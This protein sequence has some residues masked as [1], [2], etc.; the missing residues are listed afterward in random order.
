MLMGLYKVEGCLG[1]KVALCATAWVYT[2][3]G[4]SPIDVMHASTGSAEG[5]SITWESLGLKR[6]SGRAML[7]SCPCMD[8]Q[9]ELWQDPSLSGPVLPSSRWR[10][11]CQNDSGCHEEFGH[12][13]DCKAP[14][15]RSARCTPQL[16]CALMAEERPA[17]GDLSFRHC[18]RPWAMMQEGHQ[19][20]RLAAKL[21]YA[22]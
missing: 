16:V 5:C 2:R 8:A 18:I 3:L 6:L 4:P 1:V 17:G 20:S 9:G 21:A 22:S 7:N 12:I 13:K 10:P 14:L 19:R 15:L 11:A